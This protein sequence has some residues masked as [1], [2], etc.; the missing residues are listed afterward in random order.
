MTSYKSHVVLKIVCFCLLYWMLF[1]CKKMKIFT[2]PVRYFI[3]IFI[4]KTNDFLLNFIFSYV[5]F[6]ENVE[7]LS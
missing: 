2:V 3:C 1:I 5:V 4:C 6:E 7:T